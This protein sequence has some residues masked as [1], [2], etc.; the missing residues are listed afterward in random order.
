MAKLDLDGLP[1]FRDSPKQIQGLKQIFS[2][3]AN[4]TN[5]DW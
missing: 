5:D 1:F 4:E 2:V 3:W